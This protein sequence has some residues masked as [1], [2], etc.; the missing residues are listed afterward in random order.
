MI[1]ETHTPR[2]NPDEA[3]RIILELLGEIK[4]IETAFM[5]IL[6]QC[7]AETIDQSS[8]SSDDETN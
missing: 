5:S 7:A 4:T 2:E 8:Q 3:I 1:T 6:D